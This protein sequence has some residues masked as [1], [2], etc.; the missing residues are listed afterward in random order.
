MITFY[1]FSISLSHSRKIEEEI[2]S[3]LDDDLSLILELSIL[4]IISLLNKQDSY[5]F[6]VI[7]YFQ[8][9]FFYVTSYSSK[10]Y[11]LVIH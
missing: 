2:F 3:P 1:H 7:L 11:F 6:I 8:M 9:R 5:Y 10:P 4:W